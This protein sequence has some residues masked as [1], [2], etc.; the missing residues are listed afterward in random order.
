MSI[1][2]YTVTNEL[3]NEGWKLVSTSYKNLNTE[4]EMI[5]PEGH[6]QF[7]TFAKWRKYKQCQECLAGDPFKIKHNK[8]PA[9]EE[10]TRRLL[11]LDAA[12]NITGYA[13]Y[14][15]NELVYFGTYKASSQ[16]ERTERINEIKKW[17]MALIDKIEPDYIA[18]ENIQLQYYGPKQSQAQVQTY[19][20]LARLQGVLLD[21]AFEMSIDCGLIYANEWQ[22]H[23]GITGERD[24]RKRQAQARVKMWFK[25][26]CTQDEADAIC[27]GRYATLLLKNTQQS[28]GEDID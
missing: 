21:T 4:L 8:I 13:I 14:D 24:E 6:R 10:N 3:E 9:K 11:A 22:S 19:N 5:C 23:F 28:W 27:I 15:N 2:I 25:Q 18:L 26:D 12:S 20:T 7:Q 1:N 17:L 16:K